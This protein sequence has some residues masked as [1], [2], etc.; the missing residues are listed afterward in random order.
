[1]LKLDVLKQK[2][3]CL[4]RFLPRF[5][6][7]RSTFITLSVLTIGKPSLPITRNVLKYMNDELH[8]TTQNQGIDSSERFQTRFP[9]DKRAKIHTTPQAEPL[10]GPTVRKREMINKR[11]V[12]DT[13]K[14]NKIVG[15]AN[16]RFYSAWYWVLRAN[17]L[18]SWVLQHSN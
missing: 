9:H 18:M 8:S 11:D 13:T 16:L 12:N 6:T 17:E 4:L 5:K 2:R 1:M 7:Y 15:N 3:V 14:K 10:Y